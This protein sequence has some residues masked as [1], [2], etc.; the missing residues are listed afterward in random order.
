M[1]FNLQ[2]GPCIKAIEDCLTVLGVCLQRYFGGIFV[3]NHVHKILKVCYVCAVLCGFDVQ[4]YLIAYRYRN[5]LFMCPQ[6]N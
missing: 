6:G 3:G 5:S 4:L 2:E 1:G